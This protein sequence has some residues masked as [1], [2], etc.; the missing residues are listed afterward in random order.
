MLLFF[1]AV[2]VFL[3]VPLMLTAPLV[4]S[5]AR[6]TDL[7]RISFVGALGAMCGGAAI[8]VWGGP[9]RRRMRGVLMAALGLGAG[10]IITGVHASLPV[11]AV[12]V[13][14]SSLALTLVN[15]VYAIIIQVK[16]PQRFHGRVF[17]LNAVLAWSTLPIGFGVLG[18]L[19]VRWFE[20]LL[21]PGGALAGS[22]GAVIGTGPGRGIGLADVVAG[23]AIMA[24][25]LVATTIPLLARFDDTVPDAVSDDLVGARALRP[26]GEGATT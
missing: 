25:V 13:F 2:N 22:V 6:V 17:A 18:P 21:A 15:G 24:V 7:G 5:F 16:T 4:L 10:F 1:A 26:G 3:A 23:L 8:V 12:G 19:A 20:P 11:I 14:G 9:R